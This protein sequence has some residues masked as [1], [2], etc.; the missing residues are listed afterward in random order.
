MNKLKK[1]EFNSSCAR[2]ATIRTRKQT[3]TLS[4]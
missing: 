3:I 1:I 2:W 4:I